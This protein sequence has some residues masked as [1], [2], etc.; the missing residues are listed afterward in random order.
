MKQIIW[1]KVNKDKI[2]TYKTPVKMDFTATVWALNCVI[3]GYKFIYFSCPKTAYYG[4][5]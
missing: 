5:A 3:S 2:G 4:S 1:K